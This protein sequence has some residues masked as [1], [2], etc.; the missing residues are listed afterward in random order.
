VKEANLALCL[1]LAGVW[2]FVLR[3]RDG[4]GDEMEMWMG[5]GDGDEDGSGLGKMCR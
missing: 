1:V 3:C 4:D 2:H 5:Y